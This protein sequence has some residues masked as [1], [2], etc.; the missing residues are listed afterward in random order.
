MA[1]IAESFSFPAIEIVTFDKGD[2]YSVV[3]QAMSTL[4]SS[5][6]VTYVKGF[7]QVNF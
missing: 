2:P 3:K 6:C 4:L 7:W 1:Y 5:N